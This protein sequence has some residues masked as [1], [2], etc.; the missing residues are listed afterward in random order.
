MILESSSVD[1]TRLILERGLRNLA[2][3]SWTYIYNGLFGHGAS[4]S[5]VFLGVVQFQ[6]GLVVLSLFFK[7]GR[8]RFVTIAMQFHQAFVVV[9]LFLKKGRP[10]FVNVVIILFL[11]K[12]RCCAV[13]TEV[14]SGAL[15]FQEDEAATSD[16][17]FIGSAGLYFSTSFPHGCPVI[18]PAVE[19][20][21]GRGVVPEVSVI[22]PLNLYLTELEGSVAYNARGSSASG[23]G[24]T[25]WKV[26]RHHGTVAA[27]EIQYKVQ[28]IGTS[29][30]QYHSS[31]S[32]VTPQLPQRSNE[33][34][35]LEMAKMIKNNR[36]FLNNNDFPHEETKKF[37][38]AVTTV[39]PTEEPE[40]SLS[41]GYEHLNTTPKTESDEIKK[42][43]VK[44]LLPILSEYEVTSDDES[45]CDV[46]DK[47][48]SSS[49]FTTFSNP[50][51][52]DNDDFTS[53]DDESLS[54][55]DVSIE[56]FKVYSNP[57]FDDDEINSDKLDPHCFN[58]KSDFVESLSN[59]DTLIDSSPKFDFLEE[60]SGAFMPTSIADEER[61]RR[62]RV[63]YIS[64]MERLFTIN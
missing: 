25:N 14:G 34:V 11:C 23:G 24:W 10:Q 20:K 42:S 64:L 46:P 58:V 32:F 7:K 5:F 54:N 26:T 38:D 16:G 61:I 6:Q 17:I 52:N 12:K 39:L 3:R 44:N 19:V 62:E 22:G 27:V 43:G 15:V 30:D 9:S 28:K 40:Y 56:E 47:D 29:F 51:F 49:V 21:K 48:E 31:Q 41:M 60:F 63:E 35:K 53:N 57:L 4:V 33:D 36:I 1:P 8:A 2:F 59:R 45:E 13:A 18:L 50:L 55:E 37:P